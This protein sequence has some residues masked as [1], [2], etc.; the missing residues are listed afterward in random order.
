MS[1]A[2]LHFDA[3]AFFAAVEQ[4]ADRH[5][6]G[7][8]I[9]VGHLH[10]GIVAS[11]SY[12]A[13]QYGVYTPMPMSRARKLCPQLVIVAPHFEL[14][15]QFSE[16]IFGLAQE[17]TPVIEKQSID[18]G[19]L[20]L[21]GTQ[22]CLRRDPQSVA[23][24]LQHTVA[25]WLKVTISQGL[26]RTKLLSQIASKLYKPNGFKVVAPAVRQELGFLH[27]LPVKWLP[28]IGPAASSLFQS[29]GIVCI[30]Q[31]ARLPVNWLTELAGRQAAQLKAFANNIDRRTVQTTPPDAQSYSHQETFESDI[32]DP[33][34]IEA[35][36]KVL[37]DRAFKRVRRDRKQIR[38][39]TVKIR[40]TDMY[41]N[42]GQFSFSEP[43]DVE[44]C[45]Y[46]AI[47]QLL[48]RLWTRRVRLRMV[49]VKLSKI[50][51]GFW[52]LDLFGDKE[53]RRDLAV[54]CDAIR[55]RFGGRALMR[56][57]DWQGQCELTT[58]GTRSTW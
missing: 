4:A 48:N 13:R 6:R 50:Y 25:E 24:T 7:K 40:Y 38:T 43:I 15:E 45:A 44:T 34:L 32:A 30:G 54:V 31:V 17:Y 33:V 18:E 36:L 47:R 19:Y 51:S 46:D 26:A 58:K 56:R 22:R 21:T 55:Q 14:Y 8:P 12:E 53:R 2:I 20:D 39:L 41:E 35:A 16:N 52:Q 49:Q 37:A 10:R 9:A 1:R 5:L 57:H 28:G 42:Q 11:A 29:A 23:Q 27:P 3:D